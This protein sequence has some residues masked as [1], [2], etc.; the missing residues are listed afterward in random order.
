MVDILLQ[1][2]CLL[3][4]VLGMFFVFIELRTNFDKSFRFFGISLI[5]L[6][7]MCA[8]DIWFTTKLTRPESIQFWDSIYHIL[9][10]FFVSISLNYLSILTA[11]R[12]PRLEKIFTFASGIFS[13]SFI[14][15]ILFKIQNGKNEPNFIYLYFFVPY[16]VIYVITAI[17]LILKGIKKN[18]AK[19]RK[20]LQFHLLGFIL[21]LGCGLADLGI[22]IG[23]IPQLVS[24]YSILGLLAFGFFATL[25]FC[26]KFIGIINARQAAFS[27]L[28]AATIELERASILK[29]L[30]ESTVNIAHEIKNFVATI[31]TNGILIHNE[32]VSENVKYA[33]Q[34]IE[35]SAER[36]ESFTKSILNYSKNSDFKLEEFVFLDVIEATI[37]D[38]F[39]LLMS[40]IFISEKI[41]GVKIFA[42]K[43]KLEQILINILKNSFEA[44]ANEIKINTENDENFI[45]IIFFDNGKGCEGKN[46]EMLGKPFFSTKKNLGGNGLGL[47][48]SSSIM[49]SFGGR[50]RFESVDKIGVGNQGL[51]VWLMFPVRK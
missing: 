39:P 21:L 33:T 16:A 20:I 9:A 45:S 51:V 15:N 50:I 38:F 42:D 11:T 19:E 10:C 46:L 13:V 41:S 36:L 48:V 24:N 14:G 2:F 23:I 12:I 1:F 47:A 17:Y 18:T 37:S 22:E 3:L 40:K 44:G 7:S 32:E 30:G 26:E 43:R 25:I 31:K 8:I 49:Q 4:L 5:L 27:K 6:S 35:R 34:R 29:Q 28:E